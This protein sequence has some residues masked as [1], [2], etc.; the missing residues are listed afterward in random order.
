VA[1]PT[2]SAVEHVMFPLAR[3][4][5]ERGI[6][7]GALTEVIKFVMIKQAERQLQ[8]HNNATP[9]D[10]RISIATGI[11]RKEVKRLRALDLD[12]TRFFQASLPM[13]VVA[14]WMAEPKLK[15]KQGPKPLPRKKQGAQAFDFEDLVRSVST[16]VRPK[17]VLDEL[18]VRGL[19]TVDK[20]GLIHLHPDNLVMNQGQEETLRYLSMNIHDHLST[21]VGNLISPEEKS[22]ERCVHY[23]GLSDV[24]VEKLRVAAEKQAMQALLAVNNVAQRL[25]EQESTRGD[26]RMNFGVYFFNEQV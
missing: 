8:G 25:L 23:H 5:L 6:S 24:A 21:A 26:Q 3:L 19:V 22:L 16:D 9:T 17:A 11:H 7:F 4:V 12:S 2:L 15:S 18:Q 10:S 13:Q 14:R 20:K 1:D